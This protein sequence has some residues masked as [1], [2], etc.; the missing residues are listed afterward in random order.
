MRRRNGG[1]G[2]DETFKERDWIEVA[3]KYKKNKI[4]KFLCCLKTL[5]AV[6]RRLSRHTHLSAP[7]YLNTRVLWNEVVSCSLNYLFS[8]IV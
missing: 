2:G 4:N 6:I 5:P 3:E 1:R 8:S 7:H